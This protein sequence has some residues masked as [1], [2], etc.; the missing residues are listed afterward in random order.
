MDPTDEN[1]RELLPTSDCNQSV[2]VCRPEGEALKISPV[3][4]ASEHMMR[5]VTTGTM[6]AAGTLEAKSDLYFDGVNDD[7]YRNAFAKM[8]PDDERR[9]FERNLK[10]SLSGARLRS[11]KITPV[12]M[13]DMSSSLHAE[14][15]YSA[16][17][18]TA[19]SHGEAI[20]TLPWIGKDFGIVNFILDGTGLDKRQKYP[21]GNRVRSAALSEEMSSQI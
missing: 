7:E 6:T 21:H 5:V 9:F 12:N 1:T 19:S 20:L 13:L 18:L 8:K 10:R 2:L 17:G 4:P 15:E 16:D 3:P 11:L 14:L